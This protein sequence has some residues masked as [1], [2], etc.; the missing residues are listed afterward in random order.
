[1]TKAQEAALKAIEELLQR[2]SNKAGHVRYYSASGTPA[3]SFKLDD[4]EKEL[5]HCLEEAKRLVDEHDLSIDVFESFKDRG[6]QL[7]YETAGTRGKHVWQAEFAKKW[8]MGPH[9]TPKTDVDA[10]FF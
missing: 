6:L 8:R 3:H 1:M 9:G 7:I 5:E 2:L 4:L 10:D